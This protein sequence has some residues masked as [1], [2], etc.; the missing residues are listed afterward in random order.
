MPQKFKEMKSEKILKTEK[1]YVNVKDITT[2]WNECSIGE[3][4]RKASIG[5]GVD[6]SKIVI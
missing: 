6:R 4:Y 3:L 1:I 2:D 5:L